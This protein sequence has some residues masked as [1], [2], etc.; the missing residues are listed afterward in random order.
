MTATSEPRALPGAPEARLADAAV[1]GLPAATPVPPWRCR[2]QSVLWWHR[3]PGA[4][5]AS[6][7]SGRTWPYVVGAVVRY[8]DSPVGPYE[9][10]LGGLLALPPTVHLPFLA[11]DSPASVQ[12]GRAHWALPKTLASFTRPAPG[13]VI[14]VGEGW[15]I[16]VTAHPRGPALPVA[17]RLRGIQ[18]DAAG[19]PV[20][21]TS[22][23]YGRGRFARIEVQVGTDLAGEVG[24]IA[25]WLRSGRHLG[26]VLDARLTVAC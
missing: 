25:G 4:L 17:G 9:E 19:G 15:Q 7:P 21:S 1:S 22:T 3:A 13:Q 24:S 10:V 6:V 11:V 23:A 16:G 26:A 2:V 5:P 14:A 20:R 12:G 8:L 18:V